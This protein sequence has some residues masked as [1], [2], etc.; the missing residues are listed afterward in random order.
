MITLQLFTMTDVGHC[1]AVSLS[2]AAPVL[3]GPYDSLLNYLSGKLFIVHSLID[4]G[5]RAS[6]S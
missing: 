5:K 1:S 6:S 2:G 4:G 3:C